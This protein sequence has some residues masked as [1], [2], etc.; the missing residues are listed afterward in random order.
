MAAGKTT[1]GSLLAQSLGCP[2]LDLDA[3]VEKKAGKTL[4]QIF[5][6]DGEPAFRTAEAACLKWALSKYEGSAAVLAL[7]GGTLENAASARAVKEKSLCI[8]LE[9]PADVLEERIASGGPSRPLASRIG[10]LLPLRIPVYESTAHI[11]LDTQGITPQ[12]IVD[13]II[14]D[15]L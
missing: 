1:V 12:Q 4:A 14:I 10:E 11:T 5:A 6:D 3:L 9:A 13:E 15:C 2:F 7:G 8:Y